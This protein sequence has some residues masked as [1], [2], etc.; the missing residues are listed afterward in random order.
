MSDETTP[1]TNMWELLEGRVTTNHQRINELRG[2]QIEVCGRDG[3]N[4]KLKALGDDVEK[5]QAR[6]RRIKR[7]FRP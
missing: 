4:G 5:T 6:S 2:I 3:R 1:I 7:P